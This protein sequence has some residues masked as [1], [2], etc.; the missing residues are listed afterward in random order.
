[1]GSKL[2][3]TIDV[4]PLIGHKIVVILSFRVEVEMKEL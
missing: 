4:I 3:G 1:M 2:L